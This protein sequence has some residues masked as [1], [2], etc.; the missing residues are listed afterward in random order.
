MVDDINIKPAWKKIIYGLGWLGVITSL[1]W[2]IVVAVL[3]FANKEKEQKRRAKKD[4][5]TKGYQKFV[6]WL[7]AINVVL[8]VIVVLFSMTGFMAAGY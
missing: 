7:G 3:Y 6:W 4:L 8:I 5:L 2:I 1:L